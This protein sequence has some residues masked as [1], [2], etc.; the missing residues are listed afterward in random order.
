MQ[1]RSG[2]RSLHH[3][4]PEAGRRADPRHTVTG[5]SERCDARSVGAARPGATVLK[6]AGKDV[7]RA[8]EIYHDDAVLEF[9]Q[10]KGRRKPKLAMQ[11]DAALREREPLWAEFAALIE[12]AEPPEFSPTPGAATAVGSR[13]S[14]PLDVRVAGTSSSVLPKRR[15]QSGS[16][17]PLDR[18]RAVRKRCRGLSPP[19]IDV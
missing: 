14:R 17:R 16:W 4:D 15:R 12:S 1:V 3:E 19:A 10:N 9:P 5:E 13:T 2:H 18:S 11:R 8:H 7:D 6:Y